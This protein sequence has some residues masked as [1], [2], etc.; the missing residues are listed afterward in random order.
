MDA[1]TDEYQPP[2]S[3][4]E[5]SDMDVEDAVRQERRRSSSSSSSS[6][7]SGS[8]RRWKKK[9]D[10]KMKAMR[11]KLVKKTKVEITDIEM[12][13]TISNMNALIY[14]IYLHMKTIYER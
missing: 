2:V 14:M 11:E 1:D 4:D 13:Y 9:M 6:S 12:S 3:E 10:T 8:E 7:S 5:E